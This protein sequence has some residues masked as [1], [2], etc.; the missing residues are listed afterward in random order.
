MAVKEKKKVGRPR[1]NTTVDK[2]AESKK[3]VEKLFEDLPVSKAATK[4]VVKEKPAPVDKDA[5]WLADQVED[6]TELI[7]ELRKELASYKEAYTKLSEDKRSGS[8]D[9]GVTNQVYALYNELVSKRHQHGAEV[10]MRLDYDGHGPK[11]LL[12]QLTSRFPFLAS[13]VKKK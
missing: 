4:T 11:G 12:Q 1:K 10:T 7:E 8:G 13:G 5:E 6:S 3:K 9:K 2:K